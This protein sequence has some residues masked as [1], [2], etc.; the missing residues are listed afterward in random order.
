V[1]YPKLKHEGRASVKKPASLKTTKRKCWKVFS[2][3]IRL[4]DSDEGGTASCYTCGALAHYKDLHAGH[5]IPGRHN[6]VLFDEDIVKPQCPRCN[7][8]GSGQY[9]IFATKLIKEHGMDWWENKL[10]G[11]KKP[12][13]YTRT[14]LEELL[15][16]FDRKVAEIAMLRRTVE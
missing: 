8:F 9:H 1:A 4:K 10:I 2:Q 5:A 6:A 7:I 12:V 11:A 16:E 14:D 13:K 3:W 15:A